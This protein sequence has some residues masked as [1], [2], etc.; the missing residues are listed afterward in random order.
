VSVLSV[1]PKLRAPGFATHHPRNPFADDDSAKCSLTRC[2]LPNSGMKIGTIS[3]SA[4]I[5]VVPRRQVGPTLLNDRRP[6][7]AA[8]INDIAVKAFQPHG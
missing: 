3:S 8:T 7:I 5:L 2:T 6:V 1:A 4:A